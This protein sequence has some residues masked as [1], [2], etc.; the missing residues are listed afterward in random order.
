LKPWNKGKIE[1]GSTW[2]TTS[3]VARLFA[4]RTLIKVGVD[5]DKA[6]TRILA[7]VILLWF[8]TRDE[9]DF[10][11]EFGDGRE[12]TELWKRAPHLCICS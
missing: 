2:T 9:I 8:E 1:E 10:R 11:L 6:A 4:V 5:S 3:I 12:V 7:A